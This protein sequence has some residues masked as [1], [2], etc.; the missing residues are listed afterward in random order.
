M[1]FK[2]TLAEAILIEGLRRF[3]DNI[4]WARTYRKEV[5]FWA[6]VALVVWVGLS[7]LTWPKLEE[8]GWPGAVF[9]A[10]VLVG[11]WVAFVWCIIFT[12]LKN[13]P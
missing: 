9:W 12:V 3:E 4:R 13:N 10:F 1:R 5:M 11:L 7:L 8:W 2:D 6:R